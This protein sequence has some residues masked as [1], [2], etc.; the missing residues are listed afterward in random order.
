VYFRILLEF[1]LNR[2][3]KF[4]KKQIN[5]IILFKFKGINCATWEA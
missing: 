1:I 4:I 3:H 2:L 5:I